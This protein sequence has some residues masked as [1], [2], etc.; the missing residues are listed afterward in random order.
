ML[1]S[2]SGLTCWHSI[3]AGHINAVVSPRYHE[4]GTNYWL[5]HCLEGKK[6][7]VQSIIDSE[8]IEFLIGSMVIKV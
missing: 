1:W 5:T 8:G 2:F 6:T 4:W 3:F 7:L